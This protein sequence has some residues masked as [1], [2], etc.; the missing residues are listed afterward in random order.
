MGRNKRAIRVK[1]PVLPE[2]IKQAYE[3][4]TVTLRVNDANLSVKKMVYLSLFNT[5]SA[6]CCCLSR[7]VRLL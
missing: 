4:D 7:I 2:N 6:Q 1:L 3:I 5:V